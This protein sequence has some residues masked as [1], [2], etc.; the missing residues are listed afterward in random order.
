MKKVTLIILGILICF[1]ISACTSQLA[2]PTVSVQDSQQEQSNS[3]SSNVSSYTQ[4]TP[5]QEPESSPG[6]T[7][8]SEKGEQNAKLIID[9]QEFQVTL[10]DTPAANAL[11]NMLP[12]ELTFEDFNGIEKIA[13]MDNELPVEGEPDEYDPDA[14]DLCLYAPWGNLSIFYNDFRN[15]S[16]LISLGHIDSGMD[17]IRNKSGSFLAR[18]EKDE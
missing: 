15:S 18:L 13:Y 16:G 4:S 8:T 3:Q 1:T 7:E 6:N 11:Y 12:L 9:G 5:S 10:Y 17:V 14:G 2:A